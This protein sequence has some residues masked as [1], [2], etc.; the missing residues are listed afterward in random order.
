[1]RILLVTTL[2]LSLGCAEERYG[3]LATTW[4]QAPA[5]SSATPAP[6]TEAAKDPAKPKITAKDVAENYRG[7]SCLL[8][9]KE[10][11]ARDAHA[12]EALL[13]ECAQRDDFVDLD[14]LLLGP[15]MKDL[16]KSEPLQL[17]AAQAIAHRGGFV[18]QD[19]KACR[20]AGMPIDDVTVAL[21]QGRKAVGKLV[22]VRG[23]V[24]QVG[25][26][27]WGKGKSLVATI[28]ESS[29]AD[30]AGDEGSARI[31]VKDDVEDT[32]RM[33]YARVDKRDSRFGK[34]H[35]L[36]I[37]MRLEGPRKKRAAKKSDD[38]D[39]PV[40]DDDDN[41]AGDATVI[42]VAVGIFDTG[43]RLRQ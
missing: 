14:G 32:G 9:A 16:K 30:E 6:A 40:S 36:L 19:S 22:L 33:V 7:S 1:M 31:P 3:A 20:A 13:A 23:A 11:Y 17:L 28:A 37:A 12:G 27:K 18:E 15:W 21:Q 42:G 29:W 41:G 38:E 5:S 24:T 4:D 35:P 25:S 34:E 26:E 2:V 10:I 8:K 39:E 43:N